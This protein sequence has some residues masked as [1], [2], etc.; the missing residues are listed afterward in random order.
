MVTRNDVAKHAGVSSATVSR[1]INHSDKVSDELKL[2]VEKSIEAL[3]YRPNLTAKSLRSRKT[4][5]IAYIVADIVN[6]YCI[7]VYKGM[8]ESFSKR[9]YTCHLVEYDTIKSDDF[10]Q[11]FD[12]F[13]IAGSHFGQVQKQTELPMIV[14]SEPRGKHRNNCAFIYHNTDKVFEE[15]FDYIYKKGHRRIGLITRDYKDNRKI[16]AYRKSHEDHGLPINEQSI[17]RYNTTN[18]HYDQ[19]NRMMKE[20]LKQTPLTTAVICQND[21]IAMGAITAARDAGYRVPED[22]AFLGNDDSVV[23]QYSYPRLSTIKLFKA[24][25]GVK[26]A[27]MLLSLI[28]GKT[29]EDYVFEAELIYRESI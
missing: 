1:V 13:I 8:V 22:I 10:Y 21:L 16:L 26:A 5:Q 7:E 15:A 2:Q 28:D 14:Q 3:S 19:G 23:A 20:L 12:G 4:Y 18:F 24:R 25:Q 11:G 6:P 27:E 29:I 9:D 17:M